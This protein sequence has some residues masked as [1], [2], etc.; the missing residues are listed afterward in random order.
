MSLFKKLRLIYTGLTKPLK[1]SKKVS[2]RLYKK[3]LGHNK[4]IGWYRGYPVYSTMSPPSLSPM[5]AN[6]NAT[7]IMSGLQNRALPHLMDIAV[8][9][10][11]NCNCEHCSFTTKRSKKVELKKEE[12]IKAIKDS[13]DLGI[14]ALNL[15]GG[16][17]LMREDLHHI[18][19]SIDKNLAVISIFTNGWFLKEKARELKKAGLMAVKVS[20]DSPYPEVHDKLRKKSGLF[21]RAIGGLIEAKKQGLLT[22]ISCCI[23]K[24]DLLDGSFEKIIKLGKKIG[25]NEI[26]VF[27]AIPVGNFSHRSDLIADKPLLED[28]I[29]ITNRY[30]S[31][32]DYPGIFV[33]SYIRSPRSMGCSGG[34][35]YFYIDSYGNVFPCDFHNKSYG[36]IKSKPLYAIWDV[37]SRERNCS[38]YCGCEMKK[39]KS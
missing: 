30:N 3:Y 26:I 31:R 23:T 27:D 17:P 39:E 14:S 8:T 21:N 19:S 18:I 35:S 7:F 1:F 6:K 10:A 4:V 5:F 24:K 28:L 2:D 38:S 34:V 20:I 13:I 25:V 22:A 37:M 12:I 36:N 11:C 33:Y 16:E 32:E 9:G 29:K 15:V